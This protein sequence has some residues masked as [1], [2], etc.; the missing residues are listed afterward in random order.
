MTTNNLQLQVNNESKIWS[1]FSNAVY[2]AQ[3]IF[4]SALTA[5]SE[6][7]TIQTITHLDSNFIEEFESGENALHP[8]TYAIALTLIDQTNTLGISENLFSNQNSQSLKFH[9]GCQIRTGQELDSKHMIDFMIVSMPELTKYSAMEAISKGDLAMPEVSSTLIIQ[10]DKL[11]SQ[12]FEQAVQFTLQ[13]PGIE[14]T[15][16]VYVSSYEQSLISIFTENRQQFPL[17]ID[18]FLSSK[19]QFLAIPRTTT[20]TVIE[21]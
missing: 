2:D 20:V 19:D 13:G 8:S 6:P 17:G 15:R 21:A 18:V 9:A 11:S 7:G 12:T 1:G 10:V 16:E 4:R 3:S 5:M 14:S